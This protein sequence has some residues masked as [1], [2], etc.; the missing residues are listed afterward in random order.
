MPLNMQTGRL[1]I[2][3]I[4]LSLFFLRILQINPSDDFT[5]LLD[6]IYKLV[7]FDIDICLLRINE[8]SFAQDVVK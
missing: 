5:L 8:M 1:K 6:F 3:V 2:Y 7:S 4:R